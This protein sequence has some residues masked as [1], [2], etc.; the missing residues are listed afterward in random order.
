MAKHKHYDL[1]VAWAGG[2]EIEYFNP[3]I[4]EWRDYSNPN[5]DV[6]NCYR[7]KPI[8]CLPY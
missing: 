8:C 2:A 3:S 1:I 6:D 7:I 4:K 5:W